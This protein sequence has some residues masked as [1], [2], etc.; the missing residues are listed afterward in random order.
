MT[1]TPTQKEDRMF[2]IGDHIEHDTT[3]AYLGVVTEVNAVTL[4]FEGPRKRDGVP[5][6]LATIYEVRKCAPPS[7]A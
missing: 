4:R 3:G 2:R 6:T 5:V 1:A 7:R